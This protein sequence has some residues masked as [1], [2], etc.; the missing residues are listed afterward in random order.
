MIVIPSPKMRLLIT[1]ALEDFVAT[2]GSAC[3]LLQ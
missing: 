1:D 2:S 3:A